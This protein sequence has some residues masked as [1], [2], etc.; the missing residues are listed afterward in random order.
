MFVYT[1]FRLSEFPMSLICIPVNGSHLMYLSVFFSYPRC[2]PKK[3][4]LKRVYQSTIDGCIFALLRLFLEMITSYPLVTYVLY[5]CTTCCIVCLLQFCI[6][7]FSFSH[8]FERYIVHDVSECSRLP[9]LAFFTS[10][11]C[12][13]VGELRSLCIR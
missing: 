5:V 1:N 2:Q 12:N 11:P 8:L 9:V 3:C 7:I 6:W 4:V 10:D 13:T